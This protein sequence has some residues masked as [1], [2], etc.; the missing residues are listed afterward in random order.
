M[1]LNALL[2]LQTATPSRKRRCLAWLLRWLATGVVLCWI[3]L[4]VGWCILEGWIVPRIEEFRP[5]LQSRASQALGV[6]V[7]IGQIKASTQ[8][9]VSYFELRDVTLL[10]EQGRAA[11]RLPSV[12]AALSPAVVWR[13]G[14]DQLVIA[15][16]E[17]DIRRAKDGKIYV[18]GLDFSQ[19][20]NTEASGVADW[21]FSQPEFVIQ[22]GTLRWHDE[23]RDSPPLALS[24]VNVAMRNPGRQHWMRIDATPPPAWGDRFSLR[25]KF[26]QPFF[27]RHAGQW[28]QWTG[29]LYGE[30]DRVDVSQ[31]KSYVDLKN[32]GVDLVQ[33][34]GALRAWAEVDQGLWMGGT[35]DIALSNVSA[36]L[37]AKLAPLG[38]RAV[39]GRLSARQSSAELAFST[40][41]LAFTTEDG[42]TWPG[43]N[44]AVQHTLGQG[45][46]PEKT[47]FKADH[48]DL[49]TL[50]QI[51][52]RLPLPAAAHRLIADW[53]FKGLVETINANWQGPVSAPVSLT[54]QGRVRQFEVAAQALAPTAPTPASAASVWPQEPGRPG[55]RG[56]DITFDLTEQGGQAKV[57]IEQGWLEFPGV[58]EEARIPVDKL[59]MDAQW[60]HKNP[61]AAWV[62]QLRR[63]VFSNQ[64]VQGQAE[65]VW[66]TSTAPS[67]P[68][69]K[70][71]LSPT[72]AAA[73][74]VAAAQTL[75][76][77]FPGV[78]DLRGTL[79]RANGNR[80]HR[81]LPLGLPAR[82]RHYVRD[83][84]LQAQLSEVQF[85]VK[86]DL[87]HMPAA[88]PGQ[89]DF[90]ISGKVHQA[91]FAF[92]P[93]GWEPAGS[94]PWPAL[95]DL[96]GQVLFQHN[97]MELN[98][99]TAQ[100]GGLTLRNGH[101]HIAD[102]NRADVLH[103]GA[104]LEG[105]LADGLAWVRNSP[106]AA[107]SHEILSQ[108]VA[109]GAAQVSLQ[110]ALPLA[111]L[112]QLT[113]QGTLI[114]PGNDVQLT[115]EIPPLGQLKGTIAFTQNGFR[116]AGAQARFLG[117]DM[118]LDGGL[119][120]TH[121]EW[122]LQ[123]Q[124]RISAEGLRQAKNLGLVARLA[125]N[126]SG[127]TSYAATLGVRHGHPE[128]LVT[129][130]LQGVALDLPVPLKKSAESALPLRFESTL[131]PGSWA[132]GQKLQDQ[133][134]FSL[135]K[136]AFASYV[137]DVS[138]AQPRVMRG[139]I[140]I[141]LENAETLPPP[142]SEV[143]ASINLAAVD[144]DAW[145]K[146]LDPPLPAG[147]KPEPG[148]GFATDA[149]T[150]PYLPTVMA[151][152]A[153]SLQFQ[154]R[155]LN[156][157]VLGGYREGPNWRANIDA[158]ELNGYLEFR[159]STA[160]SAGRL[161]ARLSRLSLGASTANEVEAFL[162]EQ[163]AS[164]PALDI[165][166]DDMQLRGK[167]LGRVEME[168]VNRSGNVRE[169]R[170]NKFN[171]T[172]PEA[173][174]TATGNWAALNAQSGPVRGAAGARTGRAPAERRRTVMN[175]KL[176]IADAGDLLKRL[177]ME[178]V[179]R[180][181]KGSLQGQIGW[182]G[183]P[184]AL[185]YPT[186]NGQFNLSVESGQFLK[187][188]PGI[189]KLLG[190]LSL[191]SL[192]RRLILDFRDVFSEGF[193]F[194][195]VRGDIAINQGLASTNNVQMKGVNAAV[196]MEGSADIAL[197]TQD[198]KVVVVPEVNAGT[199]SLIATAINPAIGIGT[200]L[201]QLFLRRPLIE[202]S[203][204]EFH[205]DGSWSDPKV[206]RVD[207]K[208]P[209]GSRPPAAK[210]STP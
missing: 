24:Q 65:V 63:L 198:L 151:V 108:A 8:G 146:L 119:D 53:G 100:A 67:M 40:Q 112:E 51:A 191:Q 14:F 92:V 193:A 29:R 124:G 72:S 135:G 54:A 3:M 142:A 35:A 197:E 156:Q 41:G 19:T 201:A 111:D 122:N 157:V 192:P 139:R 115:P 170:L 128:I 136:L 104:D 105:P 204:Q 77:R 17:L 95:T 160:T 34:Y 206:T 159:P 166:V 21:F 182:V 210:S 55:M 18:A 200:F 116:V 98:Q 143:R 47:Q 2:Q 113:T 147:V 93:K 82:T 109:N 68:Q 62:V 137:R 144:L 194:D 181:G 149:T 140:G 178:G 56:A 183:S 164:I 177:G 6:Q 27:S 127:S 132:E 96:T 64:D 22:G 199:A 88:D 202:G 129:S 190:V 173:V 163:P 103:V 78:L 13:W 23:L 79:S 57:V 141:G 89:G 152:Q 172:T 169:W 52:N 126:A 66:H 187:A 50:A 30:L 184:L 148:L 43:G 155:Q 185:D 179:V 28:A 42:L 10:D 26:A 39:T 171:I 99:I 207:R 186:L 48:L 32:W 161:F 60:E 130:P 188:D 71:T 196:L 74:P 4:G 7:R 168:A 16:P 131:V 153:R 31:L 44:V 1:N 70:P 150:D 45:K 12:M 114:L 125:Q 133:W 209:A 81:Y 167:R 80:V 102:L 87:N 5:Q 176:D 38:L 205:V 195:F 208:S 118:R 36:Q 134:M 20:Q 58:F 83:A 138:G 121:P 69:T 61:D 75:D 174:L 15:Q 86:G 180:R 107:M 123:A 117:G 145:G 85:K 25:G 175:F 73:S 84:L 101:A 120:T 9:V 203:T 49:A 33:G 97:R 110:M 90:L 76:P 94:K 91:N 106:L 11:L 165:V 37:G 189:A 162:D 46:K 158:A 59:S 154:G